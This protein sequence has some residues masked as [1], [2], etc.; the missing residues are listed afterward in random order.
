MTQFC[1]W[2][3]GLGLGKIVSGFR[4]SPVFERPV[5]ER[6]DLGHPLY[7]VFCSSALQGV[8]LME[9]ENAL[10]QPLSDEEM[11]IQSCVDPN[12]LGHQQPMNYQNYLYVIN[13]YM[14]FFILVRF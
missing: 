1:I 14:I 2:I 6:P 9:V 3:L 5:F 13:G 4:T 11:L 10:G 8:L 7:Y 12:D